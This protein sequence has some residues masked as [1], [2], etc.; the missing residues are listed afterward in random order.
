MKNLKPIY[1]LDLETD[2]FLHG[3][4]PVAFAVGFWNGVT[5]HRTWGENCIEEMREFLVK[6]EPGIIYIH[7]GGKFDVVGFLMQWVINQPM[8]VINNRIVR[9]E[10]KTNHVFGGSHE[11]RDSFSI[12][13]FSLKGFKGKQQKLDIE[14]WKLEGYACCDLAGRAEKTTRELYKDE[15]DEYLRMDCVVLWNLCTAFVDRFGDKLT[16]GT[17][18]MGE[19]KRFH[20][21]ET[22]SDTSDKDIRSNYFYGGRVQCFQTGILPGE[23]KVYDVNSMYPF[24]MKEYKHPIGQ[25]W[26]SDRIEPETC[27]VSVEGYNYGAF[28]NRKKDGGI[29]FVEEFGVFHVS[30]HEWI[31]AIEYDLFKPTR[32]IRTVNFDEQSSFAEFVNTF[33]DARKIAKAEG[34]SITELLMKF[35]LNS[36]YGKFAQS[37]D[38]YREYFITDKTHFVGEEWEATA[39]EE[40]YIIWSKPSI[41]ASRYNVAT[42]A[43]ITGAARSVLLRA[44]ATA[45]EPIYC[46]TDSI[47]CRDLPGALKSASD[48]GSW[49]LEADATLAAIAGKKTYAFFN[50]SECV[51][52]A[53]KGVRATPIDILNVCS[54]KQIEIANDAPSFKLDGRVNF[55]TRTMRIT[56]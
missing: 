21:F 30:I 53:S 4:I 22:L 6:Q 11:I 56:G 18:A 32:I 55:I 43:S 28:P 52:L 31:A 12:M 37:P 19:I 34:D 17:T 42:G 23:W 8:R 44:I 50:G 14:M 13:P 20:K 10:M 7:N 48:L 38:N 46:D 51:K 47:V 40:K 26:E 29:G 45:V 27:F 3:R 15:I 33:Y 36:G 2:P 35:V 1:T 9:C 41:D 16:I 24:V 5:Y 54:G 39:M 25:S 49:K